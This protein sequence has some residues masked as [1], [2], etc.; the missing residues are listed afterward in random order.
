MNLWVERDADNEIIGSTGFELSNDRKHALIR[1]VAVAPQRRAAGAGSRLARYA[2]GQAS[3]MGA[4]RAWLFSRRSGPFWQQLGFAGADL[5]E[6]AAALP[7]THQVASSSKVGNS[8]ARLHGR[9]R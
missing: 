4:M 1:S 7:E 2:M 3:R 5:Y 9:G 6:L 8:N